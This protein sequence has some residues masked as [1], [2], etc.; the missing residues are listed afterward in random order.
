M[1]LV[2][3]SFEHNSSGEY[4]GAIHNF[5]GNIT[6][7]ESNFAKNAAQYGGGAIGN[8][9]GE[10]TL[11][12]STLEGNTA[13]LDGGAIYDK[14]KKSLGIENCTFKGNEPDDVHENF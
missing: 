8:N 1:S 11:T 9:G 2:S 12:E 7:T 6:V 13:Q 10:I 14:S 4:G 3:C 5:N